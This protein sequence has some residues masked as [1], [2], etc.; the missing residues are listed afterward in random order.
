MKTRILLVED[1]IN[2]ARFIALELNAEGYQFSVKHDIRTG[3]IAAQV[4][5]PDVIVLSWDLPREAGVK[6][7]YQ[8]RA[9]GNQVPI[10]G[11]TVDPKS[12][13][14]FPQDIISWLAKPFSMNDLFNA[15]QQTRGKIHAENSAKLR[16]C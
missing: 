16:I 13:R 3:L 12:D 15:I 7:H 6:L 14:F 2:L 9:E 5:S 10:I 8:L 1:Q 4:W 11:M